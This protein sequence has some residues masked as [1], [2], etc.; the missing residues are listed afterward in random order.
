MMAGALTLAFSVQLHAPAIPRAFVGTWAW[1]SRVDRDSAGRESAEPAIG[2]TPLGYLMYDAAG[3]V[4]AQLMA[5]DRGANA[6]NERFGTDPTNSA[7]ICRYDAYFGRVQVD[8]NS[9]TVVHTLEGALS[10][11]DVGKQ[12]RR[13]YRLRGDTLTLSFPTVVSGRAVTRTLTLRRVSP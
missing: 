9:A 4:A 11:G 2:R 6:C 12:L 8:T 13:T 7:A 3:H 1:V 10:P 5:S